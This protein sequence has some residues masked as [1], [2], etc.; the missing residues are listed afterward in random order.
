MCER[1]PEKPKKHPELLLFEEFYLKISEL[2]LVEYQSGPPDQK[3]EPDPEGE[4]PFT[5]DGVQTYKTVWR[6]RLLNESNDPVIIQYK[7]EVRK[8]SSTLQKA[9]STI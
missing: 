1:D 4:E 6:L 3:A 7:A 2:R 9:L 8:I 5:V